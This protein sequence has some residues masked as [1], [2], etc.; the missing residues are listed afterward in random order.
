VK[1]HEEAMA[2]PNDS[3]LKDYGEG[4]ELGLDD[5]SEGGESR[6]ACTGRYPGLP[7]GIKLE[8]LDFLAFQM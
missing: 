6:R 2:M 7:R 5:G 4:L 8:L 1:F 3:D